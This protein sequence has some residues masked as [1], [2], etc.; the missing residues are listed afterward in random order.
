ME[1]KPWYTSKIVWVNA[2]TTLA[3]VLEIFSATSGTP[4]VPPQIVPYLVAGIAIINVILRVWFTAQ[5]VTDSA[6]ARVKQAAK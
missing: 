4:L 1:T 5:P 6:A 2:L 3:L